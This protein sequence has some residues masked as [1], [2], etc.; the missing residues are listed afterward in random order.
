MTCVRY[1]TCNLNSL[2]SAS[3]AATSEAICGC[4]RYCKIVREGILR[5]SSRCRLTTN[6]MLAIPGCNCKE[7][8]VGAVIALNLADDE[9]LQTERPITAGHVE[10]GSANGATVRIMI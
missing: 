7:C 3:R 8:R 2:T 10:S 1:L 5:I 4:E 6:G 9:S